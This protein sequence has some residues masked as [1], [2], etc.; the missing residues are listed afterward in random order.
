MTALAYSDPI[1]ACLKNK[2]LLP[3]SSISDVFPK[4]NVYNPATDALLGQVRDFTKE[5]TQQKIKACQKSLSEWQ[6][7]GPYSRGDIL[8]LWATLIYQ[9][10]EDLATI[11]TL[12]Q[13]KPIQEARAEIDYAKSFISWFAEE[14]KRH[15]GEVI[16]SSKQGARM[17]TIRQPIG[18]T[19]A[20]TPWNFPCAMITRKASAA[21]AAGCSMLVRPADETPFSALAL[22]VLAQQAGIPASILTTVTGQAEPIVN[23]FTESPTVKAMSFTGSTRVGKL[24]T[25]QCAGTLK[26]VSMEL[27]GHAPFIVLEDADLELAVQGVIDAKFATSG[28]D[29]LAVNKCFVHQSLY[30][31]FLSKVATKVEALV[32]GNGLDE[33][34]DIGPLISQNAVDKCQTQV[35]DALK[36][37]A[38]LHCGGSSTEHGKQFFSPTLLS[39]TTPEMLI[40]QEETFGPVLAVSSFN[41]TPQLIEQSNNTPYGL[42]AY[43]YGSDQSK[44]WHLAEQLEYGMIAVNTPSMT[45]PPIPFG[46]IKQSGLGREGSKYGLDEYSEIKYVCLGNI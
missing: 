28:Q 20:V 30:Q 17:L 26:K 46:G 24:I 35:G 12:E 5:E 8:H 4:F 9:N 16:P 10:R 31:E 36:K 3:T 44:L 6:S 45:G 22:Q 42:A 39:N 37:G 15:Y 21:L 19:A 27:G 34:I 14:G 43:I 18:V 11:I 13:G 32:V 25:E 2:K 7:L 29:C 33:G 23:E 41:D 40:F 1:I 38:T